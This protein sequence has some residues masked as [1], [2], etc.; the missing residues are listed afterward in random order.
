MTRIPFVANGML[1]VD[2]ARDAAGVVVGSPAWFAWLAADSS[3]SFSFRS[4]AGAYT[5]R[6]ER[7]QR[8]GAYWVAYRTAA[9]RQYKKYLGTVADLTLEHLADAAAALAER[10]S[11]AAAT[12]GGTATGPNGSSGGMAQDAAG[13]LLATKLFVPRPRAHLVS[14]PRLLARLDE[15]LDGGCSLLS[16]P[17]GTGKTTLLATWVDRLDRPVAWLALDERD[18]E[19]HQVLRYLIACLQT[20]A[21]ECG[22][23]ALALLDAPPTAPPDVVLSSLLNDL[24]AQP[25]PA[26]LVLDDYHLVRAPAV[27]AAI[28]FLL[29]HLP[30]T[31]HLAIATREDPPLPLPRLRAS[32]QMTEVRAADL[33]FNVEEAAAFLGA[34]VRMRLTAQQM[35]A[36]VE[37][38]EGWAAGLQL[39]GLALR[40]HTDPA[41]FVEAFTGGHRLVVDY[42]MAEVLERQPAPVRRFLLVTSVLDRLCAPLCDELVAG[43]PDSAGASPPAINS[44]QVLE[45]L[46]G[47]NLFLI[48]L[49]DDRLWYRYHHLF[50]DVLRGRLG[51][52][53]GRGAAALLHRKA[54]AWFGRQGLL[55]EAIEHALAGDAVD[56]AARWLD[57]MMPKVF[58][59]VGIHPALAGWLTALPDS[60]VR[61]R[62]ML[63]LMRAWLSIHSLEYE[64]AAR[65][66]EAAA[67]A[68]P[69][70]GENAA[71]GAVA[72]T[73]AFLA[74]LGPAAAP[75]DVR[76]WAEQALAELAPDDLAFR[77]VAGLS[78][79]QAALALG[80]PD[81]AEQAFADIAAE[82]QAAGLLHGGLVATTHQIN[83][84][85]L[86]GARRHAL[87]TGR[88]TLGWAPEYIGPLSVALLQ[89]VVADLLLEE[90]AL[91]AAVPLATDA[92]RIQ[93]QYGNQ[94]PLVLITSLSLA[95]LRLAE[96]NAAEAAA[97]LAEVP[98]LVQH[99][100]FDY[101][102]PLL[103]A[104]QAQVRVA[105][106]ETATAVAWASTVEPM[107]LP[108]LLHFHPHFF[109][110]AVEA[111]CVTPLRILVEEGTS[112]GDAALLQD[113]ERRLDAAWQLAEGQ[114][115]GWL[116]LRVLIMQALVADAR[117]DHDGA[118]RAL[119]AA[120][121]E[122]EPEGVIRPFLDE[123]SPMAA[124]LATLRTA[125]LDHHRRTG[126]RLPDY[127]DTLLAAFTGQKPPPDTST[128]ATAVVTGSHPEGLVEPLSTRELDVLRLLS[129]GRSNAE[130]ARE[131]FVEQSTVKTHLIHL[132]RKLGVSSRTQAIARARAL[133]L[134]D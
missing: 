123:G 53:A 20:I 131:L 48:P 50:T 28:E 121:A 56:D 5:A 60:L 57:A 15:G 70:A 106:G 108:N 35:A 96:G 61:A 9:G 24:A 101:L 117:R 21:P 92:L 98:P 43:E 49:D 105:V 97:V 86:R 33:S 52:E 112:S 99:G 93:R 100:P 45:K 83:V 111:S 78:R 68:Q 59:N 87:V 63:C 19:V 64:L 85:R 1:H 118:L 127:L 42:L 84:A 16:A 36:L 91:E 30:P 71:R 29:N 11:D 88:A 116:R 126:G 26:L 132:Y 2:A 51:R 23:T 66:T 102:A 125:S 46:E 113:A 129:A 104:A 6:K 89:A 122:A 12:A 67:Q 120:I 124:L 75:E 110:A 38:T 81:Q 73:R 82:S 134:L 44:Q 25:T 74:T 54:S 115:L 58:A 62:P 40:D 4:P 69:A 114:G 10:V 90:N 31:L 107:A 34:D 8:G 103:Y 79:G 76:T 18:Q 41:A 39:A 7:K 95:R 37:R 55:P 130:I 3:R 133:Q 128:R 109:A 94:P 22:R 65:W 17:A 32:G 13:L 80:H 72:A 47:A 77:G 27:H 14:R 119:A